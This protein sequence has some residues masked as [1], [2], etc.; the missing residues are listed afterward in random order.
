ML[1]KDKKLQYRTK[2]TNKVS[3]SLISFATTFAVGLSTNVNA[4]PLSQLDSTLD[5]NDENNISSAL[6]QSAQ[7]QPVE[8]NSREGKLLNSFAKFY[9][10]QNIKNKKLA[11]DS[12]FLPQNPPLKK[13][14]RSSPNDN[15]STLQTPLSVKGKLIKSD[16][17][18]KISNIGTPSFIKGINKQSENLSPSYKIRFSPDEY[19]IKAK[20][21]AFFDKYNSLLKLE[22]PEQ[23]LNIKKLYQ[24]NIGQI[25]TKYSQEYKGIPIWKS[26]LTTHSNQLGDVVG[27]SGKFIPTP[28][29]IN[30]TPSIS[31]DEAINLAGSNLPFDKNNFTTVVNSQLLIYP[32]KKQLT[33]LLTWEVKFK[34]N[35]LQTTVLVDAT[36][37][38][39]VTSSDNL[40]FENVVGSGNG[41]FGESHKINV[42][43]D[44]ST[45]QY[46]LND[47]SKS[48]FDGSTMNP[49]DFDEKKGVINVYD[50]K[51]EPAS[52]EL[53]DLESY[54]R[55][56][57]DSSDQGWL[58]DG[59]SASVNLSKIYDYYKT[60]FN[61]NSLDAKGGRI[62]GLVRLG[63]NYNN[64]FWAGGGINMMFFGDA[65]KYA[66]GLDVVAHEVSHG[67]TDAESD[68]VYQDQP[69]A[70]NESLSDIF[71][72]MVERYVTGTND[73]VMGTLLSEKIRSMKDPSLYNDPA[74]MSDYVTTTRDHGGVHTN[75]GIPNH[76]F[77]LLAEGGSYAIGHDDAAKIFYRAN[78]THLLPRSEFS[79]LRQACIQSADDL[80]GAKSKQSKAVASAFDAVE[81]YDAPTTPPPSSP[82]KPANA[83]DSVIN[84]TAQNGK[85]YLG[86]YEKG[87]GD[88]DGG[89]Y[90]KSK[91]VGGHRPAVSGD[92]TTV[93]FISKEH[94][95]CMADT[96]T[97][98]VEC[99]NENDSFFSVAFS[100][101]D[102]YLSIVLK[103]PNAGH[104]GLPAIY[105]LDLTKKGA[106]FV[107]YKL[108]AAKMDDS[109]SDNKIDT[110]DAMDFSANGR[111]LVYDALNTFTVNNKQVGAWSIYALDL[112]TNKTL[113]LIKPKASRQVG[114]PSLSNINNN[115]MA[116]DFYNADTK[117]VNVSYADLSTGKV[118]KVAE[119]STYTAPSFTGDDKS[120]VYSVEDNSSAIGYSLH[121]KPLS[122]GSAKKWI[123][124][125]YQ[126]VV[127]RR[128]TIK[129]PASVDLQVLQTVRVTANSNDS[130]TFKITVKNSGSDKANNVV[131]INNFTAGLSLTGSAPAGCKKI[132]AQKVECKTTSLKSGSEKTYELVLKAIKT[133]DQS[134][135]AQVTSSEEDSNTNNN[136]NVLKF[137]VSKAGGGSSNGGG[138]SSKSGGGSMPWLILAALLFMRRFK[139][140]Y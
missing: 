129:K 45:G 77:Y 31:A 94:D 90:F 123:S 67:V 68:L 48:M 56:V 85:L 33:P 58:A 79:D 1:T 3:I 28:S 135:S 47:A 101:D 75:S 138:G 102:H 36:T 20:N 117:V 127:Y 128:G 115:L 133:G 87:L 122:G 54:Y 71:G 24:D 8:P 88:T 61:R 139:L 80:F 130:V 121:I 125:A 91:E 96:K 51:N 63:K 39:I 4:S 10:K 132:N 7:F 23:E 12:S 97:A 62:T 49:L 136:T 11:T 18:L 46:S 42:W 59:V 108:K 109:S 13:S 52:N 32:Q 66:G 134:N 29:N 69:G 100:P 16:F 74:K 41:V 5:L 73:W 2:Y 34:T 92:G 6:I 30:L 57:S 104:A 35:Y 113:A 76:A 9:K 19:S 107:E 21:L 120:L 83:A 38:K 114:F 86:R 27:M 82:G 50:A 98:K 17:T 119:S 70:I 137:K 110:V 53:K 14:L 37:G 25:H 26:E 112:Q 126:G 84:I 111:Y 116:F 93:A 15:T 124:N 22:F 118:F 64:A 40:R 65:L 95:F 55:I 78:T 140:A 103:D 81:I 105:L 43:H 72:E 106:E 44:S 89:V 99:I 131:L 60:T